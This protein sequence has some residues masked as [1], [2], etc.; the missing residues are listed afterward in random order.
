[1]TARSN[2]LPF[3]AATRVRGGAFERGFAVTFVGGL[4]AESSDGILAIALNL[5]GIAMSPILI[6][7]LINFNVLPP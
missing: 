3:F 2:P 5:T 6:A 4:T 7:K 1:L